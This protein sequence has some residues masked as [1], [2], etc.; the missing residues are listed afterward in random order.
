G[1]IENWKD[2]QKDF[3][4]ELYNTKKSIKD[5]YKSLADEVVSI[6]KEM[7]E[8]MRDIELEAHQKATQD[9]IDEI[10]KTD[11]EAKFQKE[12]KERQD[13]IQKLTDQ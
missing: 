5:I 4:L 8:K 13:S 7:Y 12:L 1:E 6:Y 3:N 10:D 11:D 2:K 9:L